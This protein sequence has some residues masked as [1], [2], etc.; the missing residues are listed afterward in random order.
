MHEEKKLHVI[1]RYC[2]FY[3]SLSYSDNMIKVWCSGK[4][5]ARVAHRALL[6]KY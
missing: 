1:D 4:T 5:S 6:M 2:N 3:S